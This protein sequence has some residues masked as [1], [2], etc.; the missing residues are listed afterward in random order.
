MAVSTYNGCSYLQWLF[1]LTMA[2][3][4][5]NACFYLQWLF[6]LTMAVS[7]VIGVPPIIDL[8]LADFVGTFGIIT[9]SEKTKT[10]P[11]CHLYLDHT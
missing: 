1:L 7:L 8:A 9:V 10:R 6:L 5:Y 11:K 2:V 3:S 4:T